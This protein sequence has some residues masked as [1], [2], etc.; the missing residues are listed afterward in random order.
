MSAQY[1]CAQINML[2]QHVLGNLAF[3]N[4]KKSSKIVPCMHTCT[5]GN[6]HLSN[7]IWTVCKIKTKLENLTF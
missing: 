1:M 6:C 3:Q 7:G 4:S 5:P 2:S